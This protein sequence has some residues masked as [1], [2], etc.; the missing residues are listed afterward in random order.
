MDGK[1]ELRPEFVPCDGVYNIPAYDKKD[2]L[3]GRAWLTRHVRML[4]GSPV[5]QEAIVLADIIVYNTN[6]RR[7]GVAD[8]LMRHI[9]ENFK[10][11]MTGPSTK[12]G[13]QLCVK[14]G[15]HFETLDGNKCLVY[16]REH[17][18]DS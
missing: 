9:T 14:W 1:I 18:Q 2:N 16:R 17:G 10:I 6:D 8:T 4:D 11:V 12:A 3:L 15:F 7:K 5:V 13:R